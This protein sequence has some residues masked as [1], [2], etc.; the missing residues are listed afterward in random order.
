MKNK[1]EYLVSESDLEAI[2]KYRNTLKPI[3]PLYAWIS[4][5]DRGLVK[6][7]LKEFSSCGNEKCRQCNSFRK[8]LKKVI[9]E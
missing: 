5:L 2:T 1:D 4:C 9:D 6:V 3:V 8:M 7:D